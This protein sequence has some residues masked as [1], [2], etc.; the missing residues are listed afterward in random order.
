M[1]TAWVAA[2]ERPCAFKVR[3]PPGRA[4]GSREHRFNGYGDDACCRAI[5][6][7]DRRF[8][9]HLSVL[10]TTTGVY[11][12]TLCPAP[13]PHLK[14]VAPGPAPNPYLRQG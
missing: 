11:R 6:T 12:R 7:R 8:D 5:E 4:R 10:A 1:P 14:V 13:R 9:G 2:R 3:K